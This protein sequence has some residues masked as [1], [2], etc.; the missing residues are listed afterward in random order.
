[1]LLL[2][3]VVPLF[4][5]LVLLHGLV[6]SRVLHLLFIL[7]VLIVLLLSVL[8][9]LVHTTQD[10]DKGQYVNKFIST[11]Y[12]TSSPCAALNSSR[13]L[14]LLEELPR[15]KPRPLN[16]PFTDLF[17]FGGILHQ[18]NKLFISGMFK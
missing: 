13:R 18:N 14:L 6:P 7:H 1:M 5:W 2:S 9:I 11:K 10:L 3:L 15:N 16:N 17:D 8:L 12:V 4:P